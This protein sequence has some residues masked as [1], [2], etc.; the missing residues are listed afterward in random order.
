MK[1][2][3]QVLRIYIRFLRHAQHKQSQGQEQEAYSVTLRTFSKMLGNIRKCK[4]MLKNVLKYKEMTGNARWK[5]QENKI[6]F[7]N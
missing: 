6:H 1:L 7:V 5:L 3:K 4:K 2:R